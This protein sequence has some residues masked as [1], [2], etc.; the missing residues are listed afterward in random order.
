MQAQ[1]ECMVQSGPCLTPVLIQVL[2]SPVCF[3]ADYMCPEMI[4]GA[5][6]NDPKAMDIWGLGICLYAM[7]AGH[8]PFKVCNP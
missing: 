8:M 6:V 7:V 5:H 1:G 2:T 3:V 4:L